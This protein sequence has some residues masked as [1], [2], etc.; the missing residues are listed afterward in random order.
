MRVLLVGATGM[1]GQGVLRECL[2]DP[3]IEEVAALGR[4]PVRIEH[5]KLRNI[6]HADMLDLSSLEEDLSGFDACLYCLGTTSVGMKEADYTRINHDMPLAL[7]GTLAGRRPGMAFVY[8]SGAGT[9]STETGRV[10]WARV[11]GRTENDLLGLP[12]RVFLMRPALIQPVHGEVSRTGLYRFIIYA[13]R[14]VFP[15]FR[16]LFP[17]FVTTSARLGRAMI[18]V[19]RQGH[20][21]A[22]LESRDINAVAQGAVPGD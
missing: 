2:L 8:V 13:L 5:G 4:S 1:V 15:L 11:K 12:L 21:K 9:D 17:G 10:M 22:V 19:A 3:D 18:R 7:A 16:V 14:P 20:R 6:V